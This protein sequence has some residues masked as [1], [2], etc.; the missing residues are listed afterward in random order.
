MNG[1]GGDTPRS[2]ADDTEPR[3]IDPQQRYPV[4][5]TDGLHPAL[6]D[7]DELLKQCNLRTQR[8]SGPGGQHRNKTSSGVFLVHDP[9]GIVGEATERRSQAENRAVALQRLRLKLAVEIRTPS[10]LDGPIHGKEQGIRQKLC[11]IP[12]RVADTN[13]NKAPLLALL[14]NDLLAVGGQPR[15]LIK[16]W[17][18]TSSAIVRLIQSHPPAMRLLQAIRQHHGLRPLA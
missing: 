15:L 18:T 17:Q 3:T 2:D 4:D 10:I 11:G 12:L 7:P 1:S 5:V 14:L 16:P 6:L 8:R 9:T 13:P